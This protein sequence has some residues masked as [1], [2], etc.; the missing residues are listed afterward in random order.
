MKHHRV[1]LGDTATI[2]ALSAA[3][4]DFAIGRWVTIASMLALGTY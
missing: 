2:T 4:L 3:I 1:T